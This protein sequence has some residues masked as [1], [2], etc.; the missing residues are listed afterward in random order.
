[1]ENSKKIVITIS[2]CILFLF[3]NCTQKHG[4]T[5]NYINVK[6]SLL[7]KL[8]DTLRIK[9][10]PDFHPSKIGK[11]ENQN[12]FVKDVYNYSTNENFLLQDAIDIET[13]RKLGNSNYYVDKNNVYFTPFKFSGNHYFNFLS[14]NL[15]LKISSDNDTLYTHKGV[16]FKGVK[17]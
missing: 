16:F 10:N 6:D 13:F 9:L 5:S 8:N 14:K 1:M 7:F 11:P 12:N 15:I 4:E 2:L 3:Q 17:I